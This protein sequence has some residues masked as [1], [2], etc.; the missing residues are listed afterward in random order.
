[1]NA[2]RRRGAR[3]QGLVEYALIIMLAAVVTIAAAFAVGLAVQR[4][5]GI[6][7]GA[8]GATK[9][10]T[11][12]LVPYDAKCFVDH[13]NN[14]TGLTF[15]GYNPGNIDLA[16]LTGS[17]NFAVGTGQNPDGTTGPVSVVLH[18]TTSGGTQPGTFSYSPW[19]SH[20][21]ADASLCPVSAAVQTQDGKIAVAP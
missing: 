2:R 6:V 14:V 1:M 5:F 20:T 15:W 10:T 9:S 4:V 7:T 13:T 18:T 8:L 16:T 21:V 17:T 19:L 11:A 3:G 12:A